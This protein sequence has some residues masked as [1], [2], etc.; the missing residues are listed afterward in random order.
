MTTIWSTLF[1][2]NAATREQNP[3]HAISVVVKVALTPVMKIIS[4][5]DHIMR[6]VKNAKVPGYFDGVRVAMLTYP[7]GTI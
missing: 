4:S 2:Q 3:P 1:A 5:K 7:V 6:A